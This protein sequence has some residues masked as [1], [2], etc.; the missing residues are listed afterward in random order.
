[1]EAKELE[2]IVIDLWQA[3]H[4]AIGGLLMSTKS[5]NPNVVLLARALKRAEPVVGVD[6]ADVVEAIVREQAE[7]DAA[8][9]E[10]ADGKP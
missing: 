10:S 4:I 1:M 3:G 7:R 5:D 8:R 2:L 9:K 6:V